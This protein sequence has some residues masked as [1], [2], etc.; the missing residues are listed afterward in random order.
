M[1]DRM[2][3]CRLI[4]L[5]LTSATTLTSVFLF[6]LY[7]KGTGIKGVRT[8]QYHYDLSLGVAHAFQRNK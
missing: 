8:W 5:K 1:I 4:K 7:F 3:G 6:H 2:V